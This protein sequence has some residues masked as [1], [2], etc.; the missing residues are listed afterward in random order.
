MALVVE[1]EPYVS[2]NLNYQKTAFNLNNPNVCMSMFVHGSVCFLILYGEYSVY[3]N[4]LRLFIVLA[5]ILCVHI[6]F[7][8]LLD[9]CTVCVG[10]QWDSHEE[11]EEGCG[12]ATLPQRSPALG[13]Q[14][15]GRGQ[16]SAT[17]A[18][19]YTL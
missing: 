9:V 7:M 6:Y 1:S 12:G 17:A 19:V 11:S 2:I 4:N 13:Q 14:A 15:E 5:L 16:I 3:I 10:D 18:H 8:G